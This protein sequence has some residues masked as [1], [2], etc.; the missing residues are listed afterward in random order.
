MTSRTTAALAA[1][2]QAAVGLVLLILWPPARSYRGTGAGLTV[3][4][5]GIA[6]IA[7]T[8]VAGRVAAAATRRRRSERSSMRVTKTIAVALLAGSLTAILTWYVAV[9]IAGLWYW[10][11][12][13]VG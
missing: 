13:L 4:I 9:S 7:G 1:L 5:I 11:H 12:H 6:A 8:A 3:A 10:D 2:L